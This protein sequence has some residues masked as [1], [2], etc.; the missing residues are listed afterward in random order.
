MTGRQ[1]TVEGETKEV[2]TKEG[3]TT[4][5][6]Q[7]KNA[8]IGS[9]QGGRIHGKK[10][11]FEWKTYRSE[12]EREVERSEKRVGMQVTTRKTRN[13]KIAARS[14]APHTG[15]YGAVGTRISEW[16]WR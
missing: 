12:G 8:R 14:A 1:A 5:G 13:A 6:L 9:E 2:V 16:G 3:D 11:S 4:G 10:M 15:S 7:I